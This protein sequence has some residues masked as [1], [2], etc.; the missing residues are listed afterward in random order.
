M[1]KTS[2]QSKQRWNSEHYAQVKISVAQEL[3]AS[4]KAACA[5]SGVSVAKKL[6]QYMSE[7]SKTAL[8]TGRAPDYSTK[9]QRR[10]AVKSI[11]QRL[12]QIKSAEA[13]SRDNIPENLQGYET[14]ENADQC[15]S[16]LEEAIELLESIY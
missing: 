8:K 5:S 10:A 2:T 11:T 4:F 6:S 14:F 15:V 16:S 1:G 12:E 3:A 13:H 9:R 7:Y